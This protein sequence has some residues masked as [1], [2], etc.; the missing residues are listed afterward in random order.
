MVIVAVLTSVIAEPLPLLPAPVQPDAETHQN[1]PT[2]TTDASYKGRLFDN[3]SDLFSYAVVIFG[4]DDFITT[5]CTKE[6]QQNVVIMH[7]LIQRG[8]K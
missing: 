5:S 8:S 4:D 7:S 1:Y 6:I 2:C 3:I